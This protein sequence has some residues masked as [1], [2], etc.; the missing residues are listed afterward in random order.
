VDKTLLT[1]LAGRVLSGTATEQEIALLHEWYDT[2]DKEEIELVF[3]PERETEEDIRQRT[4]A[5][6]QQ[7]IQQTPEVA[8]RRISRYARW[9]AAASILGALVFTGRYLWNVHQSVKAACCVVSQ[10]IKPKKDLSPGGNKATLLL[11]DGS[12]VDLRNAQNGLIR[13]AAGTRIDKQDGQLIYDASATAMGSTTDRAP[14]MNTIQTPRGGQY[15]LI[16]PDGTKVWLDAASSLSYPTAFTGKDR[17][18]Q[19]KG[20][21]Y[22]E[23]A[24]DKSKPFTVVVGDV[25]VNVLGTHFNVMAYDDENAIKTTL[26]EGAVK[27]TRG[28]ASH[29]LEP[30]QQASCDK[31]SGSFRMLDVDADEAIAWKNG[32]FQFAGVPIETVMRQIA[33]WYDV[34]VEYQGR[35]NEHFR[36]TIS[37]SVNVSEVFKMLELTGA[38]HFS[39]DGKKIIVKP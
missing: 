15:Q 28:Q 24:E 32:Y 30:G 29:L 35:T 11:G 9:I 18:V 27:V 10:E 14:E 22:F 5:G 1:E 39:I 6:L 37:R 25:Q 7:A 19:L 34:E 2:A 36:G 3:T 26:L 8:P 20:E 38:V 17:Q 13:N 12:V 31:T 33:R 21:A 4:F 23:V 16:L